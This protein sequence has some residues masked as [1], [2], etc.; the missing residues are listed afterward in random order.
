M[1]KLPVE[2]REE[3]RKPFGKVVQ[4]EQMKRELEN[5]AKPLIAV[6]DQCNVDLISI[7]LRPDISIFDFKIK[8]VEVDQS[9]KEALASQVQQALVVLSPPGHITDDLYEAVRQ[10]LASKKGAV[11]VVGEEDL[12]ALVVMA[13]AKGGTLVYGQPQEG[14][15]IVQL[16]EP[17]AQKAKSL[18][19]RMEKI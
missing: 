17:M 2:L 16:G 12:S 18:I 19:G 10:T 8:R 5:C 9:I 11:F 14:A 6:G 15:V 1:L 7:G 4:K 13:E 3:I